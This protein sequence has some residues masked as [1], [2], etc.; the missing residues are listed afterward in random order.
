MAK[1]K[2][3]KNAKLI[4]QEI[5]AITDTFCVEHLDEEY[6]D[7]C[8]K[9][10][11]KLARKKKPLFLSGQ[12]GVWAAGIVHAVGWVN[13]LHDKTQHPHMTLGDICTKSGV[14]KGSVQTKSKQIRDLLGVVPLD[15]EYTLPSRMADNPLA[16]MVEVD[17]FILDA[18]T[19][20][21]HIQQEARQRGL[22]P[23][24]AP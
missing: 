3:T 16:W 23:N 11:T 5:Q 8:R 19:L 13:F 6:R 22:I 24:M 18:R 21:E 9:V 10:I 12:S 2:T 4:A 14:S 1:A 17:G 20:P 15:P 7:L